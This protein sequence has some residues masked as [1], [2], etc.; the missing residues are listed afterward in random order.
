MKK[1]YA[2]T[3]KP[4]TPRIFGVEDLPL[5]SNTAPPGRV[6]QFKPRPLPP[7]PPQLFPTEGGPYQVLVY[8]H[9]GAL[10]TVLG[11]HEEYRQAIAAANHF[12]RAHRGTFDFWIRD[13]GSS[14]E[15][16]ITEAGAA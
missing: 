1:A 2:P 8:R 10:H 4:H 12:R 5:W 16:H 7:K 6:G 14:K 13:A 3:G 15:Y 9:D 11:F